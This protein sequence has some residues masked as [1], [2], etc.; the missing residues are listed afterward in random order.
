MN[1]QKPSPSN[2]GLLLKYAGL[3]GQILVS[4]GIAVFA[5]LKL[6]DWL[7]FDTPMFV[8][9]LPLAVIIVMIYQVIKDT[10]K[11]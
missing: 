9:I 10:S 6:D 2:K 5:G 4:L 8:W 1:N 11:K 7:E 3:A